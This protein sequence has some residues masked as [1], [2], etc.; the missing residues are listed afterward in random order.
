MFLTEHGDISSVSGGLTKR[1]YFAA[2]ALAGLMV[3][4]V[5]GIQNSNMDL[6]NEYRAKFCVD[7]ADELLKQLDK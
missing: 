3:Q 7:M 1:E 2:Q 6:H 5:P 4:A